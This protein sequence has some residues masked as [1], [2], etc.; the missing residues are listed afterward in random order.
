MVEGRVAIR[1]SGL[2]RRARPRAHMV[3]NDEAGSTCAQSNFSFA[4]NIVMLIGASRQREAPWL[5]ILKKILINEVARLIAKSSIR[6]TIR[7]LKIVF[8][9]FPQI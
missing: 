7:N 4:Y 5:S 2:P 9:P 1:F 6:M 3:R 8:I